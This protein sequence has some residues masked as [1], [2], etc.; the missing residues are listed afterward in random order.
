[1]KRAHLIGIGGSGLS[2]IARVL[3]EDGYQVSGSDLEYS[4]Y[5]RGLEDLGI[6][7]FVGHDAAQISGKDFVLRSSAIPDNNV[8]VVAALSAGIPVYKRADFLGRLTSNKQCIA[9]AGTHGKTTTTAMIS[10][11]LTALNLDPSF[12][13]GGNSKNL[14]TNA[15]AGSG[16]NFVIEADEYD[17]MFLGLKPEIA[18]VTNVEHDHPDNFPTEDDFF[19]AFVEFT[20]RISAKGYFLAC[21][22]DKNTEKLLDLVSQNTDLHTFCYG[23]KHRET[24][25]YP[26]FVGKNLTSD[27]NGSYSFDFHHDQAKLIKVK[28]QVPGLHNVQNSLASLGVAMVLGLPIESAAKAL[29]EFQGTERRFEI[30]GEVSGITIIDD[31]AHHPTEIKA[32]LETA[33]NRYPNRKIWAVWQPHTYTRTEA[34]FDQYINSFDNADQVVVTEI[35][36]SREKIREDFSSSQVVQAMT[37]PDVVF[38]PNI[39]QVVNHLMANLMSGDVVIVLSAGDANQICTQV[40]EKL[41]ADGKVI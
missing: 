11:M 4:S 10:W 2:A 31:Y 36:P 41:S 38:I 34:L 19:S 3:V 29:S 35:F 21:T 9:I 27:E 7:I 33:R 25:L 14:H 12:I 13:I 24:G 28:L 39:E 15:H 5:T 16:Q 32:T 1:M 17:R 20:N 23:L 37:R 40:V 6:R 18:V 26:D 22:D 8:E 30:T